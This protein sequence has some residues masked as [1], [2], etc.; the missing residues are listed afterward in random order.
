MQATISRRDYKV[1]SIK[2]ESHTSHCNQYFDQLVAKN[3]KK[4]AAETLAKQ[5]KLLIFGKRDTAFHKWDLVLTGISIVNQT[6]P[7]IWGHYFTRVNLH[8]LTRI[9]LPD[10]IERIKGLLIYGSIFKNFNSQ[11]ITL[12]NFA[13]LPQFWWGMSPK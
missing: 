5:Q 4:V 11:P 6:T 9:K 2:E 12:D 3:E 8:S 13:L 10:W 1:N 7:E